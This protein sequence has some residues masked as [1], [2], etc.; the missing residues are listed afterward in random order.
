MWVFLEAPLLIIPVAY[1]GKMF[2]G[3]VLLAPMFVVAARFGLWLNARTPR[4]IVRVKGQSYLDRMSE[5]SAGGKF[6]PQERC[7]FVYD[8]PFWV[9]LITP[10]LPVVVLVVILPMVAVSA[11]LAVALLHEGWRFL[12][13]CHRRRHR[14][15][16]EF[17][18]HH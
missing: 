7:R 14:D 8:W 6:S 1:F 12:R 2:I 11:L 9:R 5:L 13:T 10:L 16:P 3:L 15:S 17:S 4:L 18:L